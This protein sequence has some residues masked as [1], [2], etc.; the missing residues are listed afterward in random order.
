VEDVAQRRQDLLTIL[1]DELG[2]TLPLCM[3]TTF[4]L[5]LAVTD[6]FILG[7]RLWRCDSK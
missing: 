5:P 2:G 4:F 6:Y 7:A 3:I 1:W